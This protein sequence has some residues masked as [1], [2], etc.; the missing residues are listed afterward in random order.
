MK[1]SVKVIILIAVIVTLAVGAYFVRILNSPNSDSAEWT[2]FV[3]NEGWGSQKISQEL[4]Q[5]GLISNYYVFELYVWFKGLNSKLQ[6]GNYSLANNLTMPEMAQILS[7]GPG[8]SRE[9]TLTFIEGWDENDYAKYLIQAGLAKDES[10]FLSIIQKKA[11]WW[12]N[13]EFLG[14]KPRNLDLEGYLFPDTYRVYR[15]AS[16]SDIV[17]KMLDN[18]DDKL[19]SELRKEIKI[20]G[21]T[22]HEVITLASIV[23]KEVSTYEDRQMVA[24]I[25][26]KRLK[27]GM[28]LQS[29]A[30]VNYVTGGSSL[31]PTEKE[32]TIDN[33]YN[34][35]KY[36][37]L[38]P[39]PIC[40]P[41]LSAIKSVIYPT[42]NPYYYFLTT[43]DGRVIYSR[44]HD[45]HV[46]AKAKYLK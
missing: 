25:F 8:L 19:T 5:A 39:G 3:I 4:E 21:K 9:M 11:D 22:I 7:R 1:K 35:Y 23:E 37:G 26:L 12:D 36:R 2:S 33:P 16:I 30:T 38:P 46:A 27:Q 42:G 24:D 13:Y 18:F 44:T 20:Q 43:P 41:S 28:G 14:S 32:T 17:E 40:N 45:E 15:D 29:D 10:D 34:T 6:P 31:R